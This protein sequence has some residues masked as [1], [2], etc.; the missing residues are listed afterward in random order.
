MNLGAC[1]ALCESNTNCKGVEFHT[2]GRCEIWTRA[3]GIES[4]ISTSLKRQTTKK[5]HLSSAES[6]FVG[7]SGYSCY[8]LQPPDFIPVDA[9]LDRA[10]DGDNEHM[11]VITASSLAECKESC[12]SNVTC[13]GALR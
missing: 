5:F 3:G 2:S 8:A 7:L 12:R 4:S 11:E 10:C 13:K 6:R 9:S 1:Q